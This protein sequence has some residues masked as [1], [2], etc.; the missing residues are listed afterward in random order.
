MW[1]LMTGM[2]TSGTFSVAM[3]G[4]TTILYI[5]SSSTESY[6][7]YLTAGLFIKFIFLSTLMFSQLALMLLSLVFLVAIF[8]QSRH[9][10]VFED[11]SKGFPLKCADFHKKPHEIVSERHDPFHQQIMKSTITTFPDGS[12][13]GA[14]DLSRPGTTVD[15]SLD[16]KTSNPVEFSPNPALTPFDVSGSFILQMDQIHRSAQENTLNAQEAFESI[17]LSANSTYIHNS[18]PTDDTDPLPVRKKSLMTPEKLV[19]ELEEMKKISENESRK[20]FHA[21]YEDPAALTTDQML[22]KVPKNYTPSK[23]KVETPTEVQ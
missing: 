16:V 12:I 23:Y 13:F 8:L 19:K 3:F 2:A 18:F 1:F 7:A 15:P 20:N 5:L 4:K 10:S 17:P 9:Q 22:P 21:R 6:H 11:T 14:T